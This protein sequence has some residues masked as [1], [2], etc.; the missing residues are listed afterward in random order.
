MPDSKIVT[1]LTEIVGQRNTLTRQDEIGAYQP[2]GA[3]PKA[4]LFP[5]NIEQVSEVLR[6]AASESLSVIPAGSGT[7]LNL[8][9]ITEGADIVLST[10]NLNRIIEHGASDL[11]ATAECGTLLSEFQSRLREQ[12]QFLPVDP[13]HLLSGATLG[14]IIASNDSGPLRLGY[15][16]MRELLIGL[17]VVRADGTVFKGGSKVVKNVAGY[18]LP[19]LFVGSL[20][21][22]GII[23]EATFR[24]YPIPESSRTCL[25]SF[26]NLDNSH[27]SVMSLLKS[28]LV[29]SSLE[30]L[31]PALAS[32]LGERAGIDVKG[33]SYTLAVRVMN[34]EKAVRDQ[35]KTILDLCSKAGGS[36]VMVEGE[37]EEKLWEEIREFTSRLS[38]PGGTV[39][40]ANVLITDVPG[41]FRLLEGFPERSGIEVYSS[42]RAG[43]GV[44]AVSMDGEREALVSSLKELRIFSEERGGSL[45]IWAADSNVKKRVGVWGNIGT[46]LG[47][48]KR[49]K[50]NFDPE[51]IL[52]P[53]R[54]V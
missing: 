32:A 20:G 12:N 21:T 53:G 29:I 16:T 6:F 14:G 9:N 34:V 40:R 4:V 43:N 10:K 24:L 35:M 2:E 46:S 13:P 19:K 7:K 48:M 36:G 49:I 54:L 1:R 8:G 51:N 41:V 5:A 15:G 23:A 3:R 38:G 28:D 25:V 18:D 50:R 52:N 42:A 22:L 30:H 33:N 44:V 45:V 39:A 47:I 17:K 26:D 11:V 37:K 31:S 27:E